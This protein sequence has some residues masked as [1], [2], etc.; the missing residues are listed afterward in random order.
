[1]TFPTTSVQA[2][3]R[4]MLARGLTIR[5]TIRPAARPEMDRLDLPVTGRGGLLHRRVDREAVGRVAE[6]VA[7]NLGTSRYLAIQTVVVIVW[8][9]VNIAV[10]F[11]RWDPYPFILLNLAFSTQAAYAAPLI[12]LAQNRQ[13]DR[14][15]SALAEDRA[16]AV[17]MRE[18]TEF[19]AREVAALRI[20]QSEAASR[21]Y[22][23]TEM[24]HQLAQLRD[25]LEAMLGRGPG[26][27]AAGGSSGGA[28]GRRAPEPVAD[29]AVSVGMRAPHQR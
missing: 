19:L 4:R 27:P 14:D 1:M 9:G 20:A 29:S 17:R 24:T 26:D 8:I 3:S 28:P 21:Q 6:L 23:R 7:R 15:R 22:L 2:A 11:M 16:A 13:D 5:S 18:D 10:G 25:D 12:L